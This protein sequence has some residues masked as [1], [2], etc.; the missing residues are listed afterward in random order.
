MSEVT[1]ARILRGQRKGKATRKMD[2][3]KIMRNKIQA[4]DTDQV[5]VNETAMLKTRLEE[6]QG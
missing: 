5:S 3:M 6:A 1:G 2:A 4:M